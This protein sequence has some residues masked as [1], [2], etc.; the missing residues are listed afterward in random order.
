MPRALRGK[1][2]PIAREPAPS[3]PLEDGAGAPA[4]G[5]CVRQTEIAAWSEPLSPTWI[6]RGFALSATGTVSRSTPAS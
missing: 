5:S 6:L 2:G 1:P 3:L 4:A